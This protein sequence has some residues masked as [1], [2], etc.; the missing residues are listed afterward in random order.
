MKVSTKIAIGCSTI[1][2]LFVMIFALAFTQE[3]SC[4]VV[5]ARFLNETINYVKYQVV[6]KASQNGRRQG[7]SPFF[8]IY[9]GEPNDDALL[10]IRLYSLQTMHE[11]IVRP[12]PGGC[13]ETMGGQTIDNRC[14]VGAIALDLMTLCVYCMGLYVVWA[15]LLQ[16]RS[17]TPD[18]ELESLTNKPTD[19]TYKID[20]LSSDIDD[21]D[22][23]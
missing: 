2:A 10:L 1:A 23:L 19:T 14:F 8:T 9:N 11:C 4:E 5:D 7:T 17:S 15:K 18:T 13:V 6:L 12:I 3:M 16:T 20:D 21:D 22:V